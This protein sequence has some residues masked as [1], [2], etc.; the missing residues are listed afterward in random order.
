MTAKKVAEPAAGFDCII[1]LGSN[2]GDKTRNIDRA[3]ELLTEP[4]DI[5]LVA[6]S[7]N[8]ATDP[9]GKLDQDW[10]VNA[11]IAVKTNLAPRDLLRRCKDIERRMGRVATEK[12]GPRII[13]LDLL[14]YRDSVLDEPDLVLPHPH[15]ADRAFVLAPLM[16]IAPDLK[17]KG[18]SVHELLEAI[19]Q[20]G[21]RPLD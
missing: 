18:R 4:G 14:I 10:F 20:V 21:V 2:L 8:F 19:D 3:I 12:W 9:W 16:D 7:R 6:R 17:I 15:I 11:C 13:D 1:A 5:R